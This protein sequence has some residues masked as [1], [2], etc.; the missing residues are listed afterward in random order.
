MAPAQ[1]AA[2]WLYGISGQTE[3]RR[4]DIL[5]CFE[6]YDKLTKALYGA[7]KQYQKGNQEKGDT[8]MERAKKRYD[9][10]LASCP[11]ELLDTL[12][13]W[14]D[15]VDALTSQDNWSDVKTQIYNDNKEELDGDIANEF[16]TWNEGVYYNSGMFAGRFE[17]VFLDN[18]PA[19]EKKKFKIFRFW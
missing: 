6:P 15:K 10:A 12:G 1:F 18:A 11:E 19:P 17:K 13:S 9:T 5:A 16:K 8:K 4:D 2:G 14:N 3:E 7:M